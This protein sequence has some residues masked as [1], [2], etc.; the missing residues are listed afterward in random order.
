MPNN[1]ILI[2]HRY[3]LAESRYNNVVKE[4]KKVM[5]VRANN[6]YRSLKAA[7]LTNENPNHEDCEL[8]MMNRILNPLRNVRIEI[9]YCHFIINSQYKLLLTVIQ[10]LQYLQ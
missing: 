5:T 4:S 9:T 1:K 10:L 7:Q 2:V 3:I 6:Y 8:M